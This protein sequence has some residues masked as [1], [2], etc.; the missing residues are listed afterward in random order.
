MG[1]GLTTRQTLGN[2]TYLWMHP[3]MRFQILTQSLNLITEANVD[4]QVTGIDGEGKMRT[5]MIDT[6]T[7]RETALAH[8]S[9]FSGRVI[10]EQSKEVIALYGLGHQL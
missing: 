6:N 8:E 5:R 4:L 7:N 10:P 2:Q 1:L 3:Q 9:S